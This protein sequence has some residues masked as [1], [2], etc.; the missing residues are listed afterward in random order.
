VKTKLKRRATA[1]KSRIDTL[2]E[3]HWAAIMEGAQHYMGKRK[4]AMTREE[5]REQTEEAVSDEGGDD[6]MLH[7][8]MFA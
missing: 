3:A 4:A 7:D 2:P 1:F 6:T 8:P 5:S